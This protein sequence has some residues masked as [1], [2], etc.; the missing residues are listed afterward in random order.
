VEPIHPTEQGG[1]VAAIDQ[2]T[3]STRLLVLE[4][5]G[6]GE[7]PLELSRAMRITRLG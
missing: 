7:D 3:N 1:R 2:G 4:P 6:P 5:R